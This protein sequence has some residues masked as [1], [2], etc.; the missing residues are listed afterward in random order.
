MTLL[1]ILVILSLVLGAIDGLCDLIAISA[2][3]K[4]VKELE[5][6]CRELEGK[7]L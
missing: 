7:D 4:R 2:L 1:W 5:D 6:R 3:N